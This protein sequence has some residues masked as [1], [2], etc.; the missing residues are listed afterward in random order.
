[1]VNT[2]LGGKGIYRKHIIMLIVI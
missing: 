1:M 2:N